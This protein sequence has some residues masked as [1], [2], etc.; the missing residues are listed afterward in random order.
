[1]VQSHWNYYSITRISGIASMIPLSDLLSDH[2]EFHSDLQMDSF[3]TSRNGQ[4]LYGCFKQSL[5]ELRT[6]VTGLIQRYAMRDKSLVDI[7]E[8][9][10]DCIDPFQAKRN[11]IDRTEKI[12]FMEM[13]EAVIRDN[14]R[15]FWR[16]YCQAVANRRGLEAQGV[17][18]PLDDETRGRL[19]RQMW[20]HQLKV[21]AV[22]DFMTTDRL[23]KNTIELLQSVQPEMRK[24][25]WDEFNDRAKL[26][27]WY[28][29]LESPM[30][31]PAT[32]EFQDV[33][34]LI[35][36]CE[37]SDLPKLLQSTSPTAA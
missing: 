12:R 19:D 29:S 36:C 9:A 20:E 34:K 24:R 15:E 33:R 25:I 17:T 3:I 30:P 4:T 22:V 26:V 31:P 13:C 6:R 8:L 18:F 28:F 2:Q 23:Q 35:E 1:L 21:M 10:C 37:L 27:D 11:A 14:E 5:R 16:F 7:D 32:L